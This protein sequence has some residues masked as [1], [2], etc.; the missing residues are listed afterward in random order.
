MDSSYCPNW[1]GT[2]TGSTALTFTLGT[3][4]AGCLIAIQNNTTQPMT[5]D[6]ASNSIT[7]NGQNSNGT[8]PAC[9][10]PTDGCK[11]VVVK[12]NGTASWDM[13]APG[14]DGAVGATGPQGSAGPT[15]PANNPS[16]TAGTSVSVTS[17][18]A[19]LFVCTSTCTVNVPP[20]AAGAQYC[21][22]NDDNVST[23]ITLTAIGSS[24][25]YENT[26]RTAYGTAGTGTLVSGGG[27]G[28]KVCIVFRDSTHYSTVAFNGTWTAN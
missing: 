15:G 7:L 17:G 23:V 22:Y 28:D 2:F 25:R 20:P 21:V 19:Q 14:R 3:P 26:A 12:A 5:V 27:V 4:I 16:P 6:V 10:S 11:V 24:G 1:L 13:S 18:I 8:I 9:S